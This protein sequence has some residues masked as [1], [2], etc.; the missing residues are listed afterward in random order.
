MNSKGLQCGDSGSQGEASLGAASEEGSTSFSSWL[1]P[2]LHPPPP[3]QSSPWPGAE[4]TRLEKCSCG[5]QERHWARGAPCCPGGQSVWGF[6]LWAG[7]EV[8]GG[9][10]CCCPGQVGGFGKEWNPVSSKEMEEEMKKRKSTKTRLIFSFSFFFPI[11][12]YSVSHRKYCK[13]DFLGNR[14]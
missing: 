4:E 5:T 1:D 9:H 2:R 10:S 8:S 3:P 12:L 14:L 11:F 6:C 13:L 7:G